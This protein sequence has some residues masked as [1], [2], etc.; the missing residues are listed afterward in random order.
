MI[1]S[2]LEPKKTVCSCFSRINAQLAADPTAAQ[3]PQ[4]N[5]NPVP[6][7]VTLDAQDCTAPDRFLCAISSFAFVEFS[8]TDALAKAADVNGA[9]V[10]GRSIVVDTNPSG[11][12]GGGGG[13]GGFRGGRGDRGGRGGGFRGGRGDRGGRGGGRGGDRGRG[14]GGGR[15]GGRGFTPNKPRIN[16]DGGGSG[17]KIAFDD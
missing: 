15:G 12:G 14:R 11:G 1:G 7:P 16:V 10:G 6:V 2:L 3:H 4:L 13:S 5:L 8:S 9:D 17:K